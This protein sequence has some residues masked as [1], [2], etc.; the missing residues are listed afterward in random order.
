MFC[1][2]PS[3]HRSLLT[4]LLIL[5]CLYSGSSQEPNTTA[6]RPGKNGLY[7]EVYLIRHDF[8]D[9]FASLNYERVIGKK[10]RSALDL[11]LKTRTES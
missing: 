11:T 6:T 8:S 3:M 10:G 7:A 4:T 1:I 9:G 5:T 2:F